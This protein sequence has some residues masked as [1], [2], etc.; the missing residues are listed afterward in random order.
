MSTPLARLDGYIRV[1]RRG[2]RRGETY[3]S[4][5]LQREAIERWAEYNRVRI[6][7]WHV[8][9]DWS[10]GASSR[11]GLDAARERIVAGATDGI[12]SWKIDRFSRNTVQ[13]LEDLKLLQKHDARLAFVVESIDTATSFGKMV[14]T[15]LLAMSEAFLDNIR[16]GWQSA[17]EKA[18][19]R[20]A[21][22]ERDALGYV[23]IDD[24]Q[25]KHVGSLVIDPDTGPLITRAYEIAAEDGL[26]AVVEYLRANFPERRWDTTDARR[27]LANRV[28]LGEIKL[29][30]QRR[31]AHD[32]LTTPELHAAAQTE[33]REYQRRG[34]EYPLTHIARCGVCGHGLKGGVQVHQPNA[35]RRRKNAATYRRYRCSNT[36]C[37]RCSVRAEHL[38]Q[39][40]RELIDREMAIGGF[41]RRFSVEGLDAARADRDKAQ[42]RLDRWV[43]DDETRDDLGEIKW[44]AERAIRRAR[45]DEARELYERL[46][47]ETAFS[48]RMPSREDLDT[49]EGFARALRLGVAAFTIAPGSRGRS[50]DPVA[51]VAARIGSFEWQGDELV[52]GVATA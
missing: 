23:R 11:P 28:Y 33:A 47:A 2:D 6:V 21:F 34:G 37:Q 13:G 41:E 10:G 40:I 4:P 20:G 36:A 27:L 15:I 35:A 16:A 43:A 29:G 9:E 48:E 38:E 12:V 18:Y 32:P 44:S 5:D 19:E 22:I 39:V 46:A 51:A 14:Y 49:P 8:D 50:R 30:K 3:L 31:I 24:P 1:S 7:A 52:A 25:H 42:R 26:P 45:R 17:Q